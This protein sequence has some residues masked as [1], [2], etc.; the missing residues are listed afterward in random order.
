MKIKTS[1]FGEIELPDETAIEFPE[2]IVG[3]KEARRFV[4]FDCGEEGIFKWLQSCDK[5][6]LAFVVCEASMIVP[7]YKV[8]IGRKEME[9]LKLDTVDDGVVCL[10]LTI[11]E[12]PQEAT[13][14][15]LGPIV[16]N[17][18]SRLGMQLILVNPDYSTRHR[19]FKAAEGGGAENVSA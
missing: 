8:M 5:P 14:N 19:I 11:P 12:S 3:F 16:M 4:M 1:R 10:I 18:E 7:E 9:T 13:A 6:E 2:G 15:L 17:S